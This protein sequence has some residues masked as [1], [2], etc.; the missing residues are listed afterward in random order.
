MF[1]YNDKDVISPHLFRCFVVFKVRLCTFLFVYVC[2]T[3]AFKNDVKESLARTALCKCYR[4]DMHKQKE[5]RLFNILNIVSHC[6]KR[7]GAL[8]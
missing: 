2:D 7:C 8:Y 6:T 5:F 1:P 3:S 4:S